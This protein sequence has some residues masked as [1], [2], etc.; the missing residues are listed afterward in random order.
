[1]GMDAVTRWWRQRCA[2]E[3]LAIILWAVVLAAVCGRGLL[4]PR[5]HTV[6]PIYA[7]AA[8]HWLDGDD[9]YQLL[10]GYDCYRYSPLVAVAFVPFGPLPGALGGVLWRLL[11]AG[12]YLAALAWWARVA[13]PQPASRRQRAV[14]CLLVLPLSIGSLNNAQSNALVIG[15]LL[16]A[17]AGT[18]TRRWTLAALCVGLA[19]FFKLYPVAVGLLLAAVYPRRFAPRLAAVLVVGLLLPFTLQRPAYVAGQY[20]AWA[21]HLVAYDHH[22]DQAAVWY[23]DVLL[24]LRV[25]LV[26][27]SRQEYLF[28]QVAAGAALAVLCLAARRA[29]WPPRRLLPLLLGLGCCWMTAFGPAT[30]SC[31][32]I[33]LAPPLAA[34]LLQAWQ[35]RQPAWAKALLVTAQVLL[36][37][38][39][40]ISWFPPLKLLREAGASP[41][42]ALLLLTCLT[43]LAVRDLA[44]RGE[45]MHVTAEAVCVPRN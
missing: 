37:L 15:L 43:A 16:A 3:Q 4:S 20:A 11:N 35:Q 14:L 38:A 13:L 31:T 34:A 33:L 27:I 18:A 40:A 45:E 21:E 28:L 17:M 7:A 8:R 1:M 39:Q 23:S 22:S 2:W 9:L 12:V 25:W 41:F 29:G 26:P 42:A 19:C 5:L 24:L 32:Y 10:D 30:E 6:Y 36:V 44:Q